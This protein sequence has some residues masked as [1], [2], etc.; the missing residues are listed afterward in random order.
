MTY[1]YV[2][3]TGDC[4]L[5]TLTWRDHECLVAVMSLLYYFSKV[6]VYVHCYTVEFA[7]SISMTSDH[8]LETQKF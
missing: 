4:N 6:S 2:M 8:V 7:C 5:C 3:C 1:A